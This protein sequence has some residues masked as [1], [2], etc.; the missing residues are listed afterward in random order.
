MVFQ[1]PISVFLITT[2]NITHTKK[3]IHQLILSF[4]K[5]RFLMML[6][7][8]P[9]KKK[10]C[11]IKHFS[12]ISNNTHGILVRYSETIYC[13]PNGYNDSFLHVSPS[14][15]TGTTNQ[16]RLKAL[17]MS[18]SSLPCHIFFFTTRLPRKQM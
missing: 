10:N 15:V 5:K 11:K 13:N 7:A 17:P 4:P 16:I 8:Q 3:R 9:L 12:T 1:M 14:T 2:I 6:T 18:Q